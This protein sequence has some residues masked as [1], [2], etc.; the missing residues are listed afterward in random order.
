MRMQAIDACRGAAMLLVC[1]SHF[2]QAYLDPLGLEMLEFQTRWITR[3]SSPCF[4]IISGLLVGYLFERDGSRFPA[5]RTRFIDRAFFTLTI[6]HLLLAVSQLPRVDRATDI[7]RILFITDV[8]AIATIVGPRLLGVFGA[9]AR[10]GIAIGLIAA[11]WA[12]IMGWRPSPDGWARMAKEILVG[13]LGP[14]RLVYNFPLLPW[15][16]L[17][18]AATVFGQGVFRWSREERRGRT[19]RAAALIGLGS[20]G[21]AVLLRLAYRVAAPLLSGGI[22]AALDALTVPA[23]RPPTPTFFLFFG[24]MALL[25]VAAVLMADD[26]RWRGTAAV[27]SSAVRVGRH[28]LVAFVVQFYVYSG[29]YV[30]RLPWTPFWPLIFAATVLIVYG[31]VAWWDRHGSHDWLTVGWPWTLPGQRRDRAAPKVRGPVS[32]A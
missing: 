18:I 12:A 23:R 20:M 3:M 25:L 5:M 29:L 30:L 10:L 11:S 6:G 22:A 21:L 9:R 19:A 31:A 16:G 2:C 27:L 28:S 24:G 14:S 13:D 1:L 15:L 17:H 8:L 4:V 26:H 32:V 7:S